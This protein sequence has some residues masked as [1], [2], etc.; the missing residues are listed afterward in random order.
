M[1]IHYLLSIDL[2]PLLQSLEMFLR[3]KFYIII[4]VRTDL[5]WNHEMCYI[6]FYLLFGVLFYFILFE[7]FFS[8]SSSLLSPFVPPHSS[9][10]LFFIVGFSALNLFW[11]RIF[12]KSQMYFDAKLYDVECALSLNNAS[13]NS[14][15]KSSLS[16]T[17]L[18]ITSV[19]ALDWYMFRCTCVQY[20]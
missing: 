18:P 15:H 5:S 12:S 1:F 8:S 17:N 4:S 20:H 13:V 14:I 9:S 3:N 10:L 11:C 7:A 2:N 6:N 16:H 19:L